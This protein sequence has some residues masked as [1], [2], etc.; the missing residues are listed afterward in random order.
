[1]KNR[2]LPGKLAVFGIGGCLL[3]AILIKRRS[4]GVAMDYR[5][6]RSLGC[7]GKMFGPLSKR[8]ITE[9]ACLRFAFCLLFGI[10]IA[11]SICAQS[12]EVLPP[13]S[14]SEAPGKLTVAPSLKAETIAIPIRVVVRD[15]HG[16]VVANLKRDDFQLYEDGRP[17]HISNFTAISGPA[18]PAQAESVGVT[19]SAASANATS[20]PGTKS[21]ATPERFV[22]LFFDDMHLQAKDLDYTRADADK[23]L[24]SVPPT[25]HVAIVT[26]TR[27][28]ELGFT[29]DH[30]SLHEAV[31]KLEIH[32][33][34][35]GGKA[36]VGGA[37]RTGCPPMDYWEADAIVNGTGQTAA[38]ILAGAIQDL[39][40]CSGRDPD[41]LPPQ[42]AQAI[43]LN[44]A[45]SALAQ[46]DAQTE[47]VLHRIE[48]V[49]HGLSSLPGQRVIV[50]ISPG[51]LY[52]THRQQL[53]D[54]I[55]RAI[56]SDVVVNTI[57]T[58]RGFDGEAQ[59]RLATGMLSQH[60]G[61]IS[62]TALNQVQ[63]RDNLDAVESTAG[64][65]SQELLAEIADSTGG[66]F[67][68]GSSN[69][70]SA[71]SHIASAPEFYYLL[72]YSPQNLA[73]DGKYHSLKVSLADKSNFT[74]RARHGFY[75]PSR[76]ETPDE[77]AKR[78]IDD[79]LFSD[80]QE[81]GLP[82]KFETQVLQETSG[83]QKMTVKADVDVS[84]LD[85]H[86]VNGISQ[87]NLTLAAAVFDND[88]NYVAGTQ[89]VDQ[90]NLT[91]ATL[92]RLNESGF[93]LD[94]DFDVKPGD[95]TVRLVVRDS[96]DGHISAE[97]ASISVPNV[98][99][100]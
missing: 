89:K 31:M 83:L 30:A 27:Q 61:P 81:H 91:D 14:P 51:F 24:T 70:V 29:T 49:V 92:A 52:A 40:V 2:G 97:N 36:T 55:D 67:F 63:A 50:L 64:S 68:D 56:R 3:L 57:E 78:E 58:R 69:Y 79:A 72:A 62:P 66:R 88:G 21:V 59:V 82:V 28:G 22:A 35:A 44:T 86:N 73:A 94:M 17:E 48:E 1:M 20:P 13:Q 26:A 76:A 38:K 95:Y 37:I 33:A 25:D 9:L 93:F 43:V 41:S 77:A 32:P 15:R 96:N 71:F 42:V 47:A 60:G 11:F 5:L 74:V 80:E 100:R 18:G 75:A 7:S 87:E 65:A 45:R 23:Y 10:A 84:Q 6:I 8:R 53:S 16:H 39:M 46:A 4:A 19:A 54:I 85:F 90:M 12:I 34:G 98:A 99:I